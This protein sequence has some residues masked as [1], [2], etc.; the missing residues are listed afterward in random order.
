MGP[1]VV[2]P[3]MRRC[4]QMKGAGALACTPA[5]PSPPINGVR[6]NSTSGGLPRGAPTPS[7]EAPRVSTLFLLA[8]PARTLV[9]RRVEH[10]FPVVN[11]PD[12]LSGSSPFRGVSAVQPFC[13]SALRGMPKC[14][15]SG[16]WP[17]GGCFC[18]GF[19]AG[20][21]HFSYKSKIFLAEGTQPLLILDEPPLTIDADHAANDRAGAPE[22]MGIGGVLVGVGDCDCH[23]ETVTEALEW[24]Q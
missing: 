9:L 21:A 4:W 2:Y 7:A 24:G 15:V 17:V 6:L 22:G 23:G 3:A 18:N 20:L 12:F 13:E 14:G 16:L 8:S 11:T 1:H 19:I 10:T 5:P